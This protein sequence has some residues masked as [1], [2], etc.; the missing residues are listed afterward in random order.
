MGIIPVA[1]TIFA[2]VTLIHRP[3]ARHS[4]SHHRGPHAPEKRRGEG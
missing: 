1:E 2:P 4:H 3:R